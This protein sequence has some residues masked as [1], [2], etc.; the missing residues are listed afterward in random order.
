M[1]EEWIK[2]PGHGSPIF[3]AGIYTSKKALYDPE[4]TKGMPINIQ[5]ACKRW[6]EEKVLAIMTVIDNALGKER[7]FGPGTWNAHMQKST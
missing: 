6:E 1:T 4:A 7:G 3:E 5:V 2:G